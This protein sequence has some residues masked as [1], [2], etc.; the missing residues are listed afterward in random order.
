MVPDSVP[1]GAVA[2]AAE[3]V[4]EEDGP[5]ISAR[6][7]VLATGRHRAAGERPAEGSASYLAL[8]LGWLSGGSVQG[9]AGFGPAIAP[10]RGPRS[11]LQAAT[12]TDALSRLDQAVL[13]FM[14]GAWLACVVVFWI[15]WLEPAHRVGWTG[16]VVN[17]VV[18]AYVSGFPIFFVVAVSRL[19][20]VNPQ[21]AIPP[22]LK[23][24]FV[25]T[26]A[27]S[28]PW[29][30][31]QATL[32]AMLAQD[33]PLPYDVWI[34]SERPTKQITDWCAERG[35]AVS[36][37]AD[38]P[39]YHRDA[40]PRRTKCKEGNL[41]YFYDHWGYRFYDVVAQLDCDHVPAPGYLTE[42]VR[43]FADPAI[44]YVAAPSVCDANAAGSW[45]ARGR[46]HKEAT[47]HG[48]FQL[49]HSDGFAPLCIGS[50][51][52]V[53]TGALREIGGIGP[54]L[55]EDFS[56][57]F[58]MNVAGWHGAFAIDAEAHGDGPDTFA[59]MT[60][61]EFQWARSLTTILLGLVPVNLRRLSWR[62][63]F[64]FLYALSYYFLLVSTTVA[65]L[66]LAPI[67]AVTGLPWINVNYL[68]FLAHWWSISI[69]LI[70]MTALLRYRGL[71]R[72]RRAPLVSWENWL[73]SLS[74]WPF[75][76]LGICAAVI[77]LAWRRPTA[78]KVT[79]K[80]PEGLEPLRLRLILPF[81]AISVLSSGAAIYGENFTAAAGYVFLSTLSGL[82]YALVAMLIAARHA[83]EVG[84]RAGTRF[85]P[86]MRQTVRVPMALAVAACGVSAV[87]IGLYPLYAI[88]AFGW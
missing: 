80:K 28:E 51:Y 10:K 68:G 87:A 15:W 67:A 9:F 27:P 30:V 21:L 23:V 8:E 36:T 63:R 72:P 33:Y 61:Q 16:L 5:A 60:T 56:T 35:V 19:R 17:S 58:L 32:E 71:L 48:P 78:F 44:G 66:T 79:P 11:R 26:H 37:R 2:Q 45:S 6:P 49:G 85:W 13:T 22:E 47:F 34:C 14:S 39:S 53:R 7:P 59:A 54:D 12:F 18:L 83:R 20:K 84:A 40:W 74:R 62:L 69:W 82:I 86:A 25:V 77:R 88:R 57:T 52:A 24:G 38:E 81:V 43:P 76:G 73:Y 70:A 42:M 50:H 65:G 4:Q 31:V 41:A 55:A 64:R 75:V 3:A 1:G 46:V 29:P